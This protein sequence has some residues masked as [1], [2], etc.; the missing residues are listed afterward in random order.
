[1]DWRA[2]LFSSA[3]PRGQC[4]TD[5]WLWS[6]GCCLLVFCALWNDVELFVDISLQA[7]QELKK[8]RVDEQNS[9]I[10]LTRSQSPSQVCGNGQAS[11]VPFRMM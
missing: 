7:E 11:F 3:S 10:D 6:S 4:E 5:L 9:S 8:A 2:S 1:M